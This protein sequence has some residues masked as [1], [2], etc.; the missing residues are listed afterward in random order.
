MNVEEKL[1]SILRDLVRAKEKRVK[2]RKALEDLLTDYTPDVVTVLNNSPEICWKKLLLTVIEFNVKEINEYH[3]KQQVNFRNIKPLLTTVLALQFKND[4]YSG[5]KQTIQH[6]TDQLTSGNEFI[7]SYTGLDYVQILSLLID[8]HTIRCILTQDKWSV[9]FNCVCS[10]ISNKDNPR[11]LC[12]E[13]SQVLVQLIDL[14]SQHTVLPTYFIFDTLRVAF[15]EFEDKYFSACFKHLRIFNMLTEHDGISCRDLVCKL[16]NCIMKSVR[17]YL[18]NSKLDS[19]TEQCLKFVILQVN[20]HHPSD[21]IEADYVTREWINSVQNLHQFLL[22]KLQLQKH[23]FQNI[24]DLELGD[25]E[26]ANIPGLFYC[27][28]VNVIRSN[29]LIQQYWLDSLDLDYTSETKKIRICRQTFVE[30]ITDNISNCSHSKFLTYLHLLYCLLENLPHLFKNRILTVIQLLFDISIPKAGV[31]AHHVTDEITQCLISI[32]NSKSIFLEQDVL[33]TILVNIQIHNLHFQ[34]QSSFYKLLS[35]ILVSRKEAKLPIIIWKDLQHLPLDPNCMEFLFRYLSIRDLPSCHEISSLTPQIELEH[36]LPRHS[37]RIFFINLLLPGKIDT[38]R[39]VVNWLT[40]CDHFFILGQLLASQCMRS[41]KKSL[42]FT[43]KFF[44][45][46]I[47]RK[48][49]YTTKE[50]TFPQD[51]SDIMLEFEFIPPPAASPPEPLELYSTVSSAVPSY[52][53]EYVHYSH[54]SFSSI[55]NYFTSNEDIKKS[56]VLL[57]LLKYYFYFHF[58]L[59]IWSSHQTDTPS[60]R[61]Q[62][63]LTSLVFNQF[64]LDLAQFPSQDTFAALNKFEDLLTELYI[65]SRDSNRSYTSAIHSVISS[66][67]ESIPGN[68]ITLLKSIISKVYTNPTQQLPLPNKLNPF[69]TS[70]LDKT[71][72]VT[73]SAVRILC[74]L[75][76][77]YD[78]ISSPEPHNI[79][80][81]LTNTFLSRKLDKI[82]SIQCVFTLQASFYF[83]EHVASNSSI[84]PYFILDRLLQTCSELCKFNQTAL[85]RIMDILQNSAPRLLSLVQENSTI[86]HHIENLLRILT[87]IYFNLRFSSA[88]RNRY[89]EFIFYIYD[90]F[91]E[92]HWPTLTIQTLNNQ[93]NIDKTLEEIIYGLD[94]DFKR[95]NISRIATLLSRLQNTRA[96]KESQSHFTSFL[97]MIG[98]ILGYVQASYMTNKSIP[99]EYTDNVT[100]DHLRSVLV[101]IVKMSV[102]CVKKS[103]F[104]V[105]Q[106]LCLSLTRL[107]ASLLINRALTNISTGLSYPDLLVYFDSNFESIFIEWRQLNQ[108]LSDFPFEQIGLNRIDFL[109]KY[110]TRSLHI[111]LLTNDDEAITCLMNSLPHLNS[112]LQLLES[113]FEH[114]VCVLLMN[115][116]N[117]LPILGLTDVNTIFHTAEARNYL[118][119]KLKIRG[120]LFQKNVESCL[121]NIFTK[122]IGYCSEQR[123]HYIQ[124]ISPPCFVIDL[125]LAY[126]KEV[127][128]LKNSL[129][130]FF[131]DDPYILPKLHIFILKKLYTSIQ[132]H[133]FIFNLYSYC[134]FLQFIALNAEDSVGILYFLMSDPVYVLLGLLTARNGKG[135]DLYEVKSKFSCYITNEDTCT[136]IQT[137]YLIYKYS[138]SRI[139]DF[140]QHTISIFMD[141]L[142]FHSK[143]CVKEISDLCLSYIIELI[144]NVLFEI[145]SSSVLATLIYIPSGEIFEEITGLFREKLQNIDSFEI[146]KQLAVNSWY[147]HMSCLTYLNQTKLYLYLSVQQGAITNDLNSIFD[148]LIQ[149]IHLVSCESNLPDILSELL[150]EIFL[151]LAPYYSRRR[152]AFESRSL[153]VFIKS[154]NL[155]VQSCHLSILLSKLTQLVSSTDIQPKEIAYNT[156]HSISDPQSLLNILVKLSKQDLDIP[157]TYS[158]YLLTDKIPIFIP[159]IKVEMTFSEIP[160]QVPFQNSVNQT[161]LWVRDLCTYLLDNYITNNT[162]LS[163]KPLTN[164]SDECAEE[165]LKMYLYEIIKENNSE[166][167]LHISRHINNG[168][169]QAYDLILKTNTSVIP[170]KDCVNES[171]IKILLE[172]VKFLKRMVLF[173]KRCKSFQDNFLLVLDINYLYL[174]CS[175]YLCT[176]YH[177]TLLYLHTYI[178][179]LIGS[180]SSHHSVPNDSLVMSKILINTY[181]VLGEVECV[182][183]VPCDSLYL[184]FQKAKLVGKWPEVIQMCTNFPFN[185]IGNSRD[186]SEAMYEMG[187]YSMVL[188]HVD[189]FNEGT[190]SNLHYESAWRL[191]LWEED[192]PDIQTVISDDKFSQQIIFDGVSAFKERDIAYV[193]DCV[194]SNAS[195]NFTEFFNCTEGSIFNISNLL[196]NIIITHTLVQVSSFTEIVLASHR[197]AK[198]FPPQPLESP[199]RENLEDILSIRVSLLLRLIK[200]LELEGCQDPSYYMTLFKLILNDI[201]SSAKLARKSHQCTE[202]NNLLH[203]LEL[204]LQSMTILPKDFNVEILTQI[205]LESAKIKLFQKDFQTCFSVLKQNMNRLSQHPKKFPELQ[206]YFLTLYGQFLSETQQETSSNVSNYFEESVSILQYLDFDACSPSQVKLLEKAYYSLAQYSDKQYSLILDYLNSPEYKMKVEL[207]EAFD[208]MSQLSMDTLSHRPIK[209]ARAGANEY[210]QQSSELERDKINFLKKAIGGYCFCLELSDTHDLSISRVICLWFDNSDNLEI[211]QIMPH[212]LHT[213]SSHKFIPWAF[214]IIPRLCLIPNDVSTPFSIILT[215]LVLRMTKDHPYHCIPILLSILLAPLDA[216]FLTDLYEYGSLYILSIKSRL[217]RESTSVLRC[218]NILDQIQSELSLTMENAF[219][220]FIELSHVRSSNKVPTFRCAKFP[221]GCAI[222]NE[223]SIRNLPV[224]SVEIPISPNSN[225]IDV[226]RMVKFEPIYKYPGGN[227]QPKLLTCLGSDGNRYQM[228]LKGKEDLRKDA[229][230]QQGFSLINQLLAQNSWFV[231]KGVTIRTYKIVPLSQGSGLISF[232]EGT[233]S[234]ADYLISSDGAHHRYYPKPTSAECSKI[235]EQCGKDSLRAYRRICNVF[236]PVFRFFFF[237]NFTDSTTWYERRMQYTRSVAVNSMAGYI[238]GVGD[239]HVDNIRIDTSTAELVHIDFGELFDSGKNLKVP[240]LVPFRLTRDIVDPMGELGKEGVFRPCCEETLKII[241]MSKEKIKSIFKVLLHTP[242]REWKILQN[243]LKASVEK[244]K[245]SK[246]SKESSQ[247]EPTPENKVNIPILRGDSNEIALRVLM[248]IN[249]KID[250]IE[251]RTPLSIAGQVNRLIAEATDE[252]NLSLMY[253]GWK[254]WI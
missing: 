27:M 215:D 52:N 238:F 47:L 5:I 173:N 15:C 88:N 80:S 196:S 115:S 184:E 94:I 10:L 53:V 199:F 120:A 228:L 202:A 195:H 37:T 78:R 159:S 162:L 19:N 245:Q 44:S 122:Y 165:F 226:V 151:L 236:H 134:A 221:R 160:L 237:E 179:P 67:L 242:L 125:N 118:L 132:P 146:F 229:V 235:L 243:C 100:S 97:N 71:H 140:V 148:L 156:Y 158:F 203:T 178:D 108:S 38:I 69:D 192:I 61:F 149:K 40:N 57:S 55:F 182:N 216:C 231:E 126:M 240:E 186:L 136:L 194:C 103:S 121:R 163:T 45:D 95:D 56:T 58:N 89:S 174:A 250:G 234:L 153:D 114:I 131:Q 157:L 35:L 119:Q 43:N 92:L 138:L 109:H 99:N 230:I 172:I 161:R 224:L 181:G 207:T 177:S 223:S 34:R 124:G 102:S 66:L 90:I 23:V 4:N 220:D 50:K 168:L 63:E 248:R 213:I 98:N 180:D 11:I 110:L 18:N 211:N 21:F 70:L 22:E 129:F 139:P 246:E 30:I 155:S 74:I 101:F 3:Q 33:G 7:L 251:G 171:S 48:S 116:P 253:P 144:V 41:C 6:I 29:H 254:S 117:Q 75:H 241:R 64:V 183:S 25:N 112:D 96:V 93:N 189:G 36:S 13:A 135:T 145:F 141:A 65:L 147:M 209:F 197:Q 164:I 143:S 49:Q 142:C 201:I 188:Q 198:D 208:K 81:F 169:K 154:I 137:L 167:I 28:L 60:V 84:Y 72:N 232:C 104:L 8:N 62:N 79:P 82:I 210:R 128:A 206:S 51:L 39:S 239:R 14:G 222:L 227:T 130:T 77:L 9:L 217:I 200:F 252:V 54:R 204:K 68:L 17:N 127:F 133:T 185:Q 20:F 190:V 225:Y 249:E 212:Y 191:C 32:V 247:K 87:S 31:P 218:K 107:K 83:S 76:S 176:D 152:L 166:K 244:Q 233:I 205:S 170:V 113:C 16:G 73:L 26:F 106:V 123:K 187:W 46:S 214:Q 219:V 2:A 42:L 24:S 59:V 91:S 86:S 105:S 12:S 85:K 193:R 1:T 150:C 111:I 175:A